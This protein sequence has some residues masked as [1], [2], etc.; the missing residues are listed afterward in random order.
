VPYG[1]NGIRSS[2]NASGSSEKTRN[3]TIAGSPRKNSMYAVAIHR[4]GPT[5][6]SRIRA[7]TVPVTMPNA[8]A[9][10]V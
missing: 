6:E 5:E 2:G 1:W 10:I 7:S 3:T 4:Y 9:P 8:N